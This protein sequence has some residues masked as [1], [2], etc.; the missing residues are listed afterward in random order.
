MVSVCDLKQRFQLNKDARKWLL[1]DLLGAVAGIVGGLGAIVFRVTLDFNRWLFFD[2]LLPK[3][4]VYA[5]GF[6]W[7]YIV[8]PI[9]GG[10]IIGPIIMKYAPETKG[11]GVPEVM[12]AVALKGGRIRKRVAFLKIFASSV[13]ISSGG[14][15]GREG[16]IAQIGASIGSF[17]GETLDLE[18]HEIRLLV[19][20]GVAAGIAGTFNAP[21]GGALFGMEILYRGIGLFNAIP[22]IFA[23]VIGA[24]TVSTYYGTS[25]SFNA[26]TSLTFTNP[27]EL[28]WYLLLGLIFGL[29]SIL[30]VKLFYGV[31]D[32]FG[33]LRVHD[34][35]KFAMG[36]AMAGFIGI[37]FP[38]YGIMGVG[39][40]GINQ[41]L[42][43]SF[44]ITMLLTLGVLKMVATAFTIGSGGSGGIFAPSLYIGAMFGGALGL[45]FQFIAPG[46]ISQ[47]FTYSLAG[48]AALFAGAAQAPLNVIIMI[49]EMANNYSLLAPIMISSVTSFMVAWL[50]MRGSSIYTLKLER[51]GVKL[52]MG[53]SFV[54]EYVTVGEIMTKN[55]ISVR[56]DMPLSAL[57]L[58][59]EESHHQGFPVTEKGRLV[60]MV[61]VNDITKVAMDNRE[62]TQVKDVLTESLTVTSPDAT[63]Q[64]ALDDMCKRN[65]GRLPVVDQGDPMHLVGIITRSDIVRAYDMATARAA[66]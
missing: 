51:R 58:L 36:A 46:M 6:N 47:P 19:V 38:S 1:L 14:S 56:A 65:V 5:Y 43:G 44:A 8:L 54:L 57:E 7:A 55:V 50:F 60:G 26:P 29:I 21:L 28:V 30:W 12:E 22:V 32:G 62:K 3:I 61:T 64:T 40:E 20:C 13:T 11:H 10:L 24:A 52:K 27:S 41:A 16:P 9:L 63:V 15:A 45:M 66:E 42:V 23:S 4:S 39:Y 53:R 33:K 48:M 59:V 34:R 18:A 37:F 17:I 2:L 31:E 25:P 35:Y 49:P